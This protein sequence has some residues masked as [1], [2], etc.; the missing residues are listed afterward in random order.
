VKV[1]EC[2]WCRVC[3]VSTVGMYFACI[4]MMCSLSV[5]F[6]VLVLN[7]HYR[8]PNTHRMPTWVYT[9]TYLLFL[10]VYLFTSRDVSYLHRLWWHPCRRYGET[11]IYHWTSRSRHTKQLFFPP[12]CRQQR[13]GPCALKIQGSLR[14]FKWNVSI[15]WQDHVRNVDVANQTGH[16]PVMYHIVVRRN[17]IV[18]HIT[19]MSRTVPVYQ[20]LCCKVE[21]SLGRFP[22]RSWKRR[23]GHHPKR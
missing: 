6:T 15:R 21:L 23:P 20:A 4:M 2:F 11:D 9:F 18:R 13:H 12:F 7:L 19:K 8:S 3:P 1:S 10:F 16:P 5:V 14:A 22:D 17:S